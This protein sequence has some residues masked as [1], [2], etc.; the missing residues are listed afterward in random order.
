MPDENMSKTSVIPD[1]DARIAGLGRGFAF[2]DFDVRPADG[3]IRRGEAVIRVEPRVMDL[4]VCLAAARGEVVSR[5]ELIRVVWR[6]VPMTDEVI[7]RCAYQLRKALGGQGHALVRTVP[8]RGYQ[9]TGEVRRPAVDGLAEPGSN[10]SAGT[11]IGAP[12]AR[13]RPAPWALALGLAGIVLAIILTWILIARDAQRESLAEATPVPR[14]LAVLPLLAADGS[15]ESRATGQDVTD[16][17]S[18]ALA[19]IEGLRLIGRD[20]ALVIS[21]AD[22]S[23]RDKARR[24]TVDAIIDGT[25]RQR[26]EQLEF[27][28]RL[29]ETA[30]AR[31]LWSGEFMA[32]HDDVSSLQARVVSA[33]APALSA[34]GA[35]PPLA[36]PSSPLAHRLY[37]LGRRYWHRRTVGSLRQAADYFRQA[38]QADPGFA[39]AWSGAADAEILPV[40][41]A[42]TPAAEAIA[43]AEPAARRALE[44]APQLA[45]AH[46]SLGLVRLEQGAYEE[47][48]RLLREASAL[49]PNYVMAHMWLGRT[50]FLAGDVAAAEAA[51]QQAAELDPESAIVQQN[52]AMVLT[53]MGR[54]SE[55]RT[56]Y[57]VALE[58]DPDAASL[59]WASAYNDW[60]GGEL[61]SSVRS[62][63]RAFELGLDRADAYGQMTCLLL[64]L[65]DADAAARW[66]QRAEQMDSQNRWV[67]AGRR[68]LLTYRR[69][70]DELIR[71]GLESYRK[72]P[73]DARVLLMMGG[74][75]LLRGDA[76]AA[77]AR[78]EAL[79]LESEAVR[80]MLFDADDA[81]R[82]YSSALNLAQAYLLSG[83][84]EKGLA[85]IH[86]VE[87]RLA[88][89]RRS[90]RRSACFDYVA[91]AALALRGQ[92]A[93]ALTSLSA[94]I[95]AGCRELWWMRIDPKFNSLRDEPQW[96][97]LVAANTREVARERSEV[98]SMLAPPRR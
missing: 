75:E 28:L 69:Q 12:D 94:A 49:N 76:R 86:E 77:R 34:T 88:E 8:K 64:D 6:G 27:Q 20:S 42:A 16:G 87:R 22:A 55:A 48:E 62:Y 92:S 17:L 83:A 70:F 58:H 51:Y 11:T 18:A 4:L 30:S 71:N 47:A 63:R 9:L 3:V 97:Q 82:G 98:N 81:E 85:L 24:L 32:A 93:A 38:A 10:A 84:P 67:L 61:V 80:A 29:V 78:F 46:A 95:E 59:W 54:H 2:A 91:A 57:Q 79:D 56:R 60:Q 44:L 35:I 33:I 31:V 89:V 45:E 39:L 73:G 66:Q 74:D 36:Q 26:G 65:E 25:V 21:Q 37:T 43:R 19:R 7:S 41:W 68:N 14:V 50:L 1:F 13:H 52:L 96:Q 5:D 23:A 40:Q 72:H 15:Q 53:R 90:G